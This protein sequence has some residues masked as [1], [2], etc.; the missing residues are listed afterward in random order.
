MLYKI[1]IIFTL[2]TNLVATGFDINQLSPAQIIQLSELKNKN[3]ET[4]EKALTSTEEINTTIINDINNSLNT[5]EIIKNDKKVQLNPFTYRN[6]EN[7]KTNENVIIKYKK[8]GDNFFKNKNLINQGTT[9]IPTDYKIN[10]GDVISIWIYGLK[11][12]NYS[13]KVDK[14]GNIN[15]PSVGPLYILGIP[16]DNLEK[17]ISNKLKLIYKNSEIYIDLQKIAPIQIII[18]GEVNA[19]GIYNLPSYSTIKEVLVAANGIAEHGSYR[20]LKLFRDNKNIKIFDIYKL[21]NGD[22]K[23]DIKY[24]LKN[25]DTLVVGKSKNQIL[26]KGEVNQNGYYELKKGENISDLLH[27]ANGL[28]YNAN[29]HNIHIKRYIEND[30][31]KI[32]EID[33]SIAKNYNLFNGDEITIYPIN[34]SK[35]SSVYLYGNVVY[36]GEKEFYKNLTLHDFFK[37][38]LNDS[39]KNSTFLPDTNMQY[40]LIKRI[41]KDTLERKIIGFKL[42]DILNN[43]KDIKLEKNDEIYIFSNSEFKKSNYIYVDGKIVESSKKYHYFDGLTL[44]DVYNFVDFKSEAY[45]NKDD[46]IC[47]VK[48][49]NTCK[50]IALKESK[51]VKIIR[52]TSNDTKVFMLNLDTDKNFLIK[53]FDK[54]EFFNKFDME[55]ERYAVIN[56]EVNFPNKYKINENTT[57]NDII[58]ISGGLTSKVYFD[59]FE[60]TRYKVVDGIR[61]QKLISM[62]LKN[63]LAKHFKINRYDEITIFK[64]PNWNETRIITIKGEVKFPGKYIV[65]KGDRISD[66]IKRVGGY[67]AEAFVD[68]AFFARESIKILKKEQLEKSIKK[69]KQNISY[70]ATSPLGNGENAQSRQMLINTLDNIILDMASIEPKGRISIKLMADLDKF[71]D[72]YYNIV[73]EDKD[74]IYIPSKNDTISVIGEVLNQ[75]TVI[76]IPDET[77]DT[78]IEKAGGLT[79]K[80]DIDNIYIVHANG[81]AEKASL[82]GIFYSASDIKT[83][84]T[85]IVPMK[86]ELQSNMQVAKDISSILYQFAVTAASLKTVGLF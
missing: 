61:E 65:Q 26:I 9:I 75:N 16:Y 18:S 11:N 34:K 54:I 35:N 30:S 20:E 85:I 24:V 1:L 3:V 70:L 36:S 47:D 50:R 58:A 32:N 42:S 7:L 28:K 74:F 56:G 80:A 43:K 79:E 37:K 66:I 15:I 33:L 62:S 63:A 23:S 73:L 83:A 64:I 5:Q 22:T 59:I 4:K 38:T 21:I 60:V 55:D 17:A 8:F 40:S 27:Y 77:V 53:P 57:I 49:Y 29:K 6:E 44:N 76:F 72:S 82:G 69:L 19:P 68:G 10:I 78:Y 2:L 25:G 48:D 31:T 67:T 12:Q 84:D 52:I 46:N 51:K 81:V 13:L 45:V 41:D 71:N 39:T 86:I 14:K